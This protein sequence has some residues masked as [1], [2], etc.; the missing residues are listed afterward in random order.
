MARSSLSVLLC[1]GIASSAFAGQVKLAVT[2]NQGAPTQSGT[3]AGRFL[4]RALDVSRQTPMD[5]I[6][7]RSGDSRGGP[8]MQIKMEQA[9]GGVVRLTVLGPLSNQGVV[10]LDDGKT[11]QT[12]LPDE[13][14]ILEQPSPQRLRQA[15]SERYVLAMNNYRFALAEGE[16]IAGREVVIVSAIPLKS[17]DLP[18]RFFYIDSETAVVLR[19]EIQSGRDRRI[20]F[21]TKSIDYRPDFSAKDLTLTPMRD[22][23][24]MRLSGPT[25]FSD[26]ASV[27]R[28]LGFRPAMPKDLPLGFDNTAM[29]MLGSEDNPM[30]AARLSDGLALLTVY[31]FKADQLAKMGA[32][33]RR[34]VSREVKGIRLQAVGDLPQSVLSEILQVFI[35]EIQKGLSPQ[36]GIIDQVTALKLSIG[37][38]EVMVYISA[39]DPLSK[40]TTQE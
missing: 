13:N 31:Q 10:S 22:V 23:R 32:E 18:R 19:T 26:P 24:R 1:L 27:Q 38:C 20:T 37:N 16:G 15:S 34:G 5:A 3:Q 9:K 14:R 11:W 7:V 4:F 35:R 28:Q 21:D 17:N 2:L 30:V 6:I 40:E 36:V 29:L 33:G 25:R 8:A 39:A 12:Y